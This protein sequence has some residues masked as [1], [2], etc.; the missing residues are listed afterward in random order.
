MFWSIALCAVVLLLGG[1]AVFVHRLL[2]T[3][4][5]LDLLLRQLAHLQ[6]VH[7]EV[8]G[9]H[10]VLVGP[11]SIDK[12]V[13]DHEAVHI[14]ARH[15]GLQPQWRGA[16]TGLVTVDGVSIG[17]IE[18]TLKEREKQP[19][20]ETHFLPAWLRLAIPDFKADDV[21]LTLASGARYTERHIRGTARITRWRIDVES[22]AVDD[23]LGHLAG[24]VVLR[25]TNPLGLRGK[26][27]G[28]WQ[29]PDS[30]TYRFSTEVRGNLDRLGTDFKLMQPA[31]LSF[32]GNL[33]DLSEQLKVSGVVRMTNFDGAPWVPAGSLPVLSGSLG[34]ITKGASVA[35]GGTLTSPAIEGGQV[36][37]RGRGARHDEVLEVSSLRIWLPRLQMSVTTK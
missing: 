14:E 4:E 21:S 37:I 28:Q 19:E 3:P 25:G 35:A 36:R 18:V 30:R 11:L 34:I 9:T 16:L 2:Y 32:A 10:G 26:V 8:T 22:F 5:G 33:L 29:L 20:S 13:V 12:V 31:Q 17:S 7:L 27:D 6:T 1:S 24:E 15:L 23:P